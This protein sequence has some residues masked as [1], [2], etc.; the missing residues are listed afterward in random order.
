MIGGAY[1]LCKDATKKKPPCISKK[2]KNAELKLLEFGLWRC[3]PQNGLP[4]MS[5]DSGGFPAE[6]L[7]KFKGNHINE[8]KSVLPRLLCFRALQSNDSSA[9]PQTVLLENAIKFPQWT[10]HVFNISP[11]L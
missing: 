10:G 7:T 6:K 1:I 4:K 11:S 5:Q 9:R 8:S 2:G 3:R